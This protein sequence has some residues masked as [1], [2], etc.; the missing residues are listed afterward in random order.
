LTEQPLIFQQGLDLQ[1][2][3]LGGEDPIAAEVAEFH[4]RRQAMI[5]WIDEVLPAADEALR[6]SLQGARDGLVQLADL[7]PPVPEPRP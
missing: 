6:D 3:R 4:R 2:R 7:V 1:A 5:D